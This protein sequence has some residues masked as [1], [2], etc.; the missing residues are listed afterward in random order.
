M[1]DG[2]GSRRT[3]IVIAVVVVLV[4]VGG[5]VWWF[6][7]RDT[8][9]PPAALVDCEAE[10]S[11]EPVALDGEWTVVPGDDV[12]AGYRIEEIFG[13]DTFKREIAGR[14]PEVTG[15]LTVEGGELSA[16]TIT[17]DTTAL[18]TDQARRDRWLKGNALDT[19]EFPEATFTLVEPIAL[20]DD[21][22]VGEGVAVDA[23]GELTLH[24]VTQEVVIP[25]E[26]CFAGDSASV[27]GSLR[28]LLEDYEIEP[29]DVP[30]LAKVDP[31][32]ILEFQL[33]FQP[34]S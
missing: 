32:G 20:P 28:I 11:A 2:K 19:D 10:G 25:V 17:V 14:S 7:V 3:W 23:A 24:G 6:F 30:G 29:P 27:A 31:D 8:A 4:L 15:S 13:G 5:T 33:T 18:A 9:P 26:A 34:S 1:S 21:P 16:T 12:F 22:A